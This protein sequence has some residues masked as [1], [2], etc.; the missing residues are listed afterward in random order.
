MPL[1][2]INDLS[3]V[4]NDV[5]VVDDL[6]LALEPGETLAIVGESG[7][8]KSMTALAV[9][10]LLP[11]EAQYRAGSI[12]L[13]DIELTQLGEK[14]LQQ[15]RGNRISM[16]FQDPGASLNPLLTVQSQIVEAIRAHRKIDPSAARAEAVEMLRLVGIPAP[17]TRLKQY[18]FELSGGLCQRIMI[19][20]ALACQPAVLIADEPT[21]ALD[22]TIQAQILNLIKQLSSELTSA[23]VLIT[24]DLGVVADM[25]DRVAVMY[26]GRI[27]EQ[28]PVTDI[29]QQPRHPYTRLLL[30]SMPHLEL[31]QKAELHVIQGQV[32]NPRDWPTGCRFR[33]RC[34]LA[35]QRCQLEQPPLAALD[36][37][38]LHRAACWYSEQTAQL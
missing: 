4:I 37:S 14:G 30:K 24:H 1:L 10:G 28:A 2:E 15:I 9:M 36:Q 18:P 6:S 26:A 33:P 29:F 35:E 25:A 11:S 38:N 16:I 17:E 19:A 32:P 27:V 3:I 13:D 8:G 21:T 12:R 22:V 7:C 34:P 20:I 5:A 31:E 23:V